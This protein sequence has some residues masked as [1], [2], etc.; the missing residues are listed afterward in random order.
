MLD[1]LLSYLRRCLKFKRLEFSILMRL[2]LMYQKKGWW[3]ISSAMSKTHKQGSKH[4]DLLFF[5]S[6][7]MYKNQ[8]LPS[9]INAQFFAVFIQWMKVSILSSKK[10]FMKSCFKTPHC[11]QKKNHLLVQV[12]VFEWVFQANCIQK[13]LGK[14]CWMN[15]KFRP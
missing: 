2:L 10:L 7:K 13:Q 15:T 4:Q 14:D 9:R 12:L 6:I 1:F 3:D 5:H 8:T 11:K